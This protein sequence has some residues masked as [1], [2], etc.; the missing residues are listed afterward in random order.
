MHCTY[1][2]RFGCNW[3]LHSFFA[4]IANNVEI[5]N[6]NIEIALQE[7]RRVDEQS[8][9]NVYNDIQYIHTKCT[10]EKS[11]WTFASGRYVCTIHRCTYSTHMDM[12]THGHTYT[13]TNTLNTR[14]KF[15]N[16]ARID[17]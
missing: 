12:D 16:V 9:R 17:V 8:K 10:S 13:N 6:N 5:C 14:I 11:K 7:E 2:M 1:Y 4:R 15:K 3:N